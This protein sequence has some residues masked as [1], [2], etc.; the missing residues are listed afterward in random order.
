V[1]NPPND[2]S[3]VARIEAL[4]RQFQAAKDSTQPP[5]ATTHLQAAAV[6]QLLR[7]G[8]SLDDL[9]ERLRVSVAAIEGL[10]K[11]QDPE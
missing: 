3:Q 8:M 7:L 4:V 11:A 1:T 5:D 6:V 9:A 2:K 10:A